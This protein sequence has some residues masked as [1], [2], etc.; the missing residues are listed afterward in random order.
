[1]AST[2]V[3]PGSGPGQD[4]PGRWPYGV[5]RYKEVELAGILS[6]SFLSF[7]HGVKPV[8]VTKSCV[9]FGEASADQCVE[10]FVFEM[11][12]RQHELV[13]TCWSVGQTCPY[14]RSISVVRFFKLVAV[15]EVA[16]CDLD[17]VFEKSL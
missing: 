8:V 7:L 11:R 12:K 13:G 10:G 17:L 2:V 4:I 16:R 15:S 14:P 9:A 5:T 6:V 3:E 1:M